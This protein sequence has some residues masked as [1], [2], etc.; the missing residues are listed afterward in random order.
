MTGTGVPL[1][2]VGSYCHCF[3]HSIAASISNGWPEMT[4]ICSTVPCAVSVASRTTDPLTRDLAASGGYTGGTI[5]MTCGSFTTPPI[6][7]G[8]AGAATCGRGGGGGGGGGGAGGAR[9]GGGDAL[10]SRIP[11]RTP[12]AIPPGIPPGT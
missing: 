3:T 11:P 5:L 6:R 2:Y 8:T 4:R 10:A 1:R 12:P 9:T 7:I